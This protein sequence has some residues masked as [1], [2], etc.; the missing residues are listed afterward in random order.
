LITFSKTSS[1]TQTAISQT[2]EARHHL[3]MVIGFG[4]NAFP[5]TESSHACGMSQTDLM[6]LLREDLGHDITGC[7]SGLHVNALDALGLCCDWARPLGL[8]AK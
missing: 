3:I 5:G 4:P 2:A 8:V 7:A 6:A 1:N